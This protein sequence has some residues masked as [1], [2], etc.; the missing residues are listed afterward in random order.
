MESKRG[1]FVVLL[2]VLCV[3]AVKLLAQ[4]DAEL[5]RLRKAGD[6]VQLERY[7][8]AE[9]KKQPSVARQAELLAELA[10]S[11]AQQASAATDGDRLWDGA[12]QTLAGFLK[13]H[14]EHPR[15]PLLVR[16]RM[17]YAYTRGEGY[18]RQDELISHD[19][20][21]AKARAALLLAEEQ[22]RLLEA[23]VQKDLDAYTAKNAKTPFE[24]LVA[25]SNDTPF[26]L[27]HVRLS[28]AQTYPIKS[29]ER[30]N[31]LEQSAKGFE[32]YTREGFTET[33]ISVRA[34]LGLAECRRLAARFDDAVR[35]LAPIEQSQGTPGPL[36]DEAL[37][38]HMNL[39][40]DQEQPQGAKAL[41]KGRTKLSAEMALALVRA[42]LIEA[43]QAAA[44]GDRAS[45]ARLQSEALERIGVGEREFPPGWGAWAGVILGKLGS[46]DWLAGDLDSAVRCAEAFQRAGRPAEAASAYRK[47]A[48]SA[49]AHSK[50]EQVFDLTLRGAT[51]LAQAGK[52]A[53]AADQFLALLAEQPQHARAAQV[54]LLAAHALRRA[55]DA[56]RRPETLEQ[57]RRRLAEHVKRHAGHET[58]GEAH[59]LAGYVEAAEG[60]DLNAALQHFARVP[61]EHRVFVA[62]LREQVRTLEKL[63]S[64]APAEEGERL[65]RELLEQLGRHERTAAGRADLAD[66]RPELALAKA[67]VLCRPGAPVEDLRQARSLLDSLL[68]DAGSTDSQ[69]VLHR[70]DRER[71]GLAPETL[72]LALVSLGDKTEALAA[73]E[74]LCREEA[75]EA[76]E[77]SLLQRLSAWPQPAG[78]DAEQARAAV[79]LS[80]AGKLLATGKP[81]PA[82]SQEWRRTEANALVVL[83]QHAEARKLFEELRQ[84]APGDARLMEDH[85]R[86][87]MRMNT[88]DDWKGTVGLWQALSA[89]RKEGTPEWLDARYQLAVALQGAGE[90]ERALKVIRVTQDLWLKDAGDTVRQEL[91]K[92]FR[93][94]ESRLRK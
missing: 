25:L 84:A 11:L 40:L 53:E 83:G 90:R 68:K 88:P 66:R 81:S 52:N 9:L 31:L 18:R 58:A 20:L 71:R 51:A 77:L 50:S 75:G 1:R 70:G 86:A 35:A 76:A 42:A 87:L 85:A 7:C 63:R 39:L 15:A 6:L 5:Q 46:P 45:A 8:R 12:D 34:H 37:A 65:T 91:Q 92:R 89:R 78:T 55:W 17:I 21:K 29:A 61:I 27:A 74:T 69:S 28:L 23:R 56:D 22:G 49:G 67:Q 41:V 43:R 3:S 62:A 59:A 94:L 57:L 4:D 64:S 54:S 48:Q 26:R 16:Q 14:A 72:V 44:R 82:Q 2:C 47:A 19:A 80:A 32:F 73:F 30:V 38:I 24:Q 36:K 10:A 60:K 33:E 79:Q 93:D 13:S